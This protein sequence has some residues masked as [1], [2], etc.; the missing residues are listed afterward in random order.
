[1]RSGLRA[2]FYARFFTLCPPAQD[3]VELSNT[4]L[5]VVADKVIDRTMEFYRV[6]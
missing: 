3:Y 2:A 5:H 6:P 1:M 4:Y